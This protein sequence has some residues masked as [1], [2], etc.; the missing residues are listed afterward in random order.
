MV[1]LPGDYIRDNINRFNNTKCVE[2][3]SVD[4]DGN[5]VGATLKAGTIDGNSVRINGYNVR[6]VSILKVLGKE[7]LQ[8]LSR[9]DMKKRIACGRRFNE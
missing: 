8:F 6:A 9:K 5:I 2:H 7:I 4:P 1:I 3:F